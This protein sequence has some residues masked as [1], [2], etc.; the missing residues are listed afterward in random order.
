MRELRFLISGHKRPVN[1]RW[2]QVKNVGR[3]A[4]A[5]ACLCAVLVGGVGSG[6]ASAGEITG[7]GRLKEV[8]ANSICAFSGLND[9]ITEEEPFK[10]QNW[11]TIPKEFRDFLRSI[12]ISPEVECNGHLHPLKQR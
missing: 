9:E 2:V 8:K 6:V 3:K 5:S 4:V 11:G 12:G 10:T 7:N 1:Q